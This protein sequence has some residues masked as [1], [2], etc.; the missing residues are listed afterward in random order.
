MTQDEAVSEFIRQCSSFGIS[1]EQCNEFIAA[2]SREWVHKEIER[3]ERNKPKLETLN[4][5]GIFLD[6]QEHEQ[7]NS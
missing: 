1:I 4:N 7:E 6:W 3:I 5:L 2:I